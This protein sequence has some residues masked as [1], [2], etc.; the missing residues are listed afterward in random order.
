M[1]CCLKEMANR[2]YLKSQKLKASV[3]ASQLLVDKEHCLKEQTDKYLDVRNQLYKLEHESTRQTWL[4]KKDVENVEN[5][6]KELEEQNQIPH[7]KIEGIKKSHKGNF[8]SCFVLSCLVNSRAE[9][10]SSLF[11][12]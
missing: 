9:K 6:K 11:C 4:L 10:M 1:S 2:S 3:D 8:P 7:S 12:R 5:E